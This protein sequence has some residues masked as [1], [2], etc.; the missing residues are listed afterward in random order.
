[1]KKEQIEMRIAEIGTL[2]LNSQKEQSDYTGELAHLHNELSLLNAPKLTE[3]HA[4]ELN[5][6]LRDYLG[7]IDLDVDNMDI[8]FEIDYDNRIQISNFD[9]NNALDDMLDGLTDIIGDFF[10]VEVKDEE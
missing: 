10:N 3:E 7:N 8:E 4:V 9:A 6:R 2:V 5:E 1:M